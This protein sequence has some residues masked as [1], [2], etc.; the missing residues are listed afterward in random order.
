ML[1]DLDEIALLLS[2]VEILQDL[3]DDIITDIARHVAFAEFARGSKVV[4]AGSLGERLYFICDGSVEIQVPDGAGGIRR[5]VEIEKG[6]VI[7]EISL[8]VN[9]TYNA[10]VVALSDARAFYLDRPG[11]QSLIEAHP[12]LAV[13]M[14]RLVTSRMAQDGGINQ[15]GRYQLL[16][17]LGEGNMATVFSAW[18][19][20]LHR[21]VAIKMLKYSLAYDETFVSRFETEARTIASLNHPNIIN[22][23]EIID[24]YSTRFIVMEKLQ[25]QDLAARLATQG[26]LPPAETRAI[27]AQIASALHYAHGHGEQ[28]IVHR[29]IKPSNI[30]IDAFGHVKLTDFGIAGP[31]RS[32]SRNIQGSPS[33]L[34]PEII[35]GDDFDGRADIYAMGIMAYHML[36]GVPPFTAATLSQMLHLQLEQAAPDIR[37]ACAAVDDDLARFIDAALRKHPDQRISDWREIRQL[38]EP[39]QSLDALLA[40]DEQALVVRLRGADNPLAQKLVDSL[41][42]W[43]ADE[44]VDHDIEILEGGSR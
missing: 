11:F 18:D 42:Q 14:S 13:V 37:L 43:L 44:D 33:Y 28:G 34:A 8:L 38:L 35:R 6:D 31:P 39:R 24:A 12:D 2:G 29:D 22:V 26:N 30:V 41:S 20:D 27:L 7:G 4:E 23:F 1:T 15:V 19:P 5:R 9:S 32:G 21:E 40:D 16:A 17:R 3:D 10:D 36:A 25:G